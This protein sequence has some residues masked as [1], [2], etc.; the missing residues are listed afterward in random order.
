MMSN[1]L[2]FLSTSVLS[3]FMLVLSEIFFIFN[4]RLLMTIIF[5]IFLILLFAANIFI[6][7]KYRGFKKFGNKNYI[8]L[9]QTFMKRWYDEINFILELFLSIIS[10]I[11]II[12][13]L[14]QINLRGENFSLILEIAFMVLIIV[15]EF[16]IID[17]LKEYK[18]IKIFFKK[19]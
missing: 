2:K 16:S 6:Y 4:H 3:I 17:V 11:S 10:V 18:K 13:F 5:S 1:T 9:I 15:E 14:T 19:S 12:E 7:T 8:E